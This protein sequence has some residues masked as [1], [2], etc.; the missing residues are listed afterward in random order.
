[1]QIW[2]IVKYD[3][4]SFGAYRDLVLSFRGH[5]GVAIPVTEVSNG[6]GEGLIWYSRKI[7]LGRPPTEEWPSAEGHSS[8]GG[9]QK[10]IPP[11][12]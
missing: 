2:P 5:E 3:V 12:Y 11:M 9:L 10:P 7:G 8:V 1:M 4:K 6:M